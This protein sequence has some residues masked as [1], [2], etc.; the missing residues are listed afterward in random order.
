MANSN[1]TPFYSGNAGID[2]INVN[3]SNSIIADLGIKRC[4]ESNAAFLLVP[5]LLK[6]LDIQKSDLTIAI[7]NSIVDLDNLAQQIDAKIDIEDGITSNEIN[8]TKFEI[9][10]LNI[11]ECFSHM[12]HTPHLEK[13]IVETLEC[14]NTSF[15]YNTVK[16]HSIYNLKN[17]EFDGC[18]TF[19]LFPLVKYLFN[20][21][22]Y[23]IKNER[24]FFLVANYIQMLDDYIDVFDDKKLKIETPVTIRFNKII[25][26]KCQKNNLADS[27]AILSKEILQ[28]LNRYFQ[29]IQIEVSRINKYFSI[30]LF[31]EWNIFHTYFQNTE[32]SLDWN[33]IDLKKHLKKLHKKIPQIICYTG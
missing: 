31:D 13:L 10:E 16:R 27:F 9:L 8:Y 33:E 5:F 19:Y 32:V 18:T 25:S 12:I 15:K 28:S 3:S 23:Q 7:S 4:K 17:T 30:D 20:Q 22:K 1:K 14:V 21:S 26:S 11:I 29:E 6:I 24:L 2:Q